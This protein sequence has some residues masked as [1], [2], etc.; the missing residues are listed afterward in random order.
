MLSS[1]AKI[2]RAEVLQKRAG[3]G[4]LQTCEGDCAS[5]RM[6]ADAVAL[7]AQR[8]RMR[9]HADVQTSERLPSCDYANG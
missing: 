5:R 7:S 3:K 2:R 8:R 9:A 6:Q 4:V 1:L